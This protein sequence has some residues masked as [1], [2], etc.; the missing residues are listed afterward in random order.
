MSVARAQFNEVQSAEIPQIAA[1]CAEL[2]ESAG[3]RYAPLITFSAPALAPA[4]AET[5]DPRLLYIAKKKTN[6]PSVRPRW[7]RPVLLL[8]VVKEPWRQPHLSRKLV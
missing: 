3:E 5:L 2:G 1:A 6:Q 4:C 8:V 7:R